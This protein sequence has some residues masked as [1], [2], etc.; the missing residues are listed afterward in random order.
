VRVTE[1]GSLR[2][3][4]KSPGLYNSFNGFP[5]RKAHRTRELIFNSYTA[6]IYDG[7]E[8]IISPAAVAFFHNSA[9]KAVK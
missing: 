5:S 8:I 9:E 2:K 7:Y 4:R 3:W 1:R 6:Q